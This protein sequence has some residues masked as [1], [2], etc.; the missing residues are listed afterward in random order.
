[1]IQAQSKEALANRQRMPR[2]FGVV[3]FI[4][5]AVCESLVN[6]HDSSITRT[7]AALV[8][9]MKIMCKG[10]EFHLELI[11]IEPCRGNLLFVNPR[12]SAPPRRLCI[13]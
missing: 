6:D 12:L 5:F 9:Q 1:V 8:W 11:A 4:D 3:K 13:F 10:R 2:F 7:T